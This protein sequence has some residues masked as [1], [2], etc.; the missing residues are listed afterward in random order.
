MEAED[1]H[2]VV[3]SDRLASFQ[4]SLREI[5]CHVKLAFKVG[6]ASDHVRVREFATLV[7]V[8]ELRLRYPPWEDVH[9]RLITFS[10]VLSIDEL[11]KPC[12]VDGRLLLRELLLSELSAFLSFGEI[13]RAKKLILIGVVVRVG[14]DQGFGSP[15]TPDHDV[16]VARLLQTVLDGGQRSEGRHSSQESDEA[17]G[18]EDR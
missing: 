1:V 6:V 7:R 18:Q 2:H 4:D 14:V 9:R 12:L 10:R 16:E 5:R 15:L 13:R 11:L 8:D 17:D 3:G